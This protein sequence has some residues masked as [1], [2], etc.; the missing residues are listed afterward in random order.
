MAYR[1]STQALAQFGGSTTGPGRMVNRANA[2]SGHTLKGRPVEMV[3]DYD[4][5]ASDATNDVVLLA[6]LDPGVIVLPAKSI[7]WRQA[8]G[9]T[10]TVDIGT[11]DLVDPEN[12]AEDD[13]DK[14]CDGLAIASAGTSRFS[15]GGT[16]VGLTTPTPESGER[17]LAMKLVSVSTPTAGA[18][19]RFNI[20]LLYGEVN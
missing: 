1:F 18:K 7:L 20:E 15:D 16:P 6:K 10:Y 17:W 8:A 3:L 11:Y 9:N 19:L 5:G 4:V 14:F 2:L 12:P 13:P